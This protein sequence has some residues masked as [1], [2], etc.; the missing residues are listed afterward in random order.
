MKTRV[1][2]IFHS[3]TGESAR[4]AGYETQQ[5]LTSYPKQQARSSAPRSSQGSS[6]V[7]LDVGDQVGSVLG[8]G[9]SREGHRVSGREIGG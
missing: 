4:A 9:H 1:M 6:L 3:H 7:R 2:K 8:G 5:V